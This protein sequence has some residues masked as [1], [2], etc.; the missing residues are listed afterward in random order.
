M[1]NGG[2]YGPVSVFAGR[3]PDFSFLILHFS[4]IIHHSSFIIHHSSFFI[5]HS[6]FFI[7]QDN[8]L[9]YIIKRNGKQ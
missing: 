7:S 9:Y 5:L 8:T 1:N 4:F 3:M 6:S 2:L